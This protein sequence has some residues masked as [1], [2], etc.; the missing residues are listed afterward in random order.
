MRASHRKAAWAALALA[1]ALAGCEGNT[2]NGSVDFFAVTRRASLDAFEKEANEVCSSPSISADGQFVAFASKSTNLH[3]DDPDLQSDIF[4]R[5]LRTGRTILASR[6]TDGATPGAKANDDCFNPKISADGR[7]V[8]FDSLATNLHPDDT[9]AVR[10]VFLRDLL[11][12]TTLLVSRNS[13]AGPPPA[14]DGTKLTERS[15]SAVISAD[16]QFVAFVYGN[17]PGPGGSPYQIRLRDV[18]NRTTV[19]VS[20]NPGSGIPFTDPCI[21]PAISADGRYVAFAVGISAVPPVIYHVYVRD[22]LAATT[23]LVSQ[24][25]G[26][27]GTLGNADSY[28]PSISSD[29]R[30]IAFE[31]DAT[32]LID[33]GLDANG[34][35]DIYV[36]D[37]VLNSTV[38]VSN[39]NAGTEAIGACYSPS[40]SSDGRYVAFVSD[41]ANLVNG[42]TNHV[43]DVF[44]RDTKGRTTVRASVRTYGSE[45]ND[46]SDEPALTA[47]GS[48]VAFS[49]VATDLVEGDNNNTVDIFV[50]GP[51]H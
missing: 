7:F 23:A 21:Q 9:D 41:A 51:L 19:T 28:R 20:I 4:V 3:P 48:Y 35:R 14:L 44:V 45:A 12:G 24:P 39:A 27:S 47:D 2:N 5:D 10:D 8:V 36:R 42:D 30:Y 25:S 15:A 29:G 31:S 34:T 16:G 43:A 6:A 22:R 33:P 32:N 50:R 40:I 18:L 49:S 17:G 26:V 13:A 1:G 37:T 11:T 38:R 46:A